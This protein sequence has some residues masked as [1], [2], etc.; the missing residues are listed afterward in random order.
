MKYSW[1]P[2][3]SSVITTKKLLFL[4][5]GLLL[6]QIAFGQSEKWSLGPCLT[7]DHFNEKD[8]DSNSMLAFPEKRHW[9]AS[10]GIIVQRT[11]VVNGLTVRGGLLY[12]LRRWSDETFFLF[13]TSAFGGGELTRVD[14]ESSLTI[15]F[16]R[17]PLLASY[18]F[19]RFTFAVGPSLDIELHQGG[20]SS[21]TYDPPL[22]P[23]P[24]SVELEA[25]QKNVLQ[26]GVRG[27]IAYAWSLS[28]S[29][30]LL[31]GINYHRTLTPR[32]DNNDFFNTNVKIISYGLSFTLLKT[33]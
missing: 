15:G 8:Y 26:L 9:G 32:F 22:P 3:M 20:S 23:D 5:S 10:L 19:R 18:Q 25:N 11:T 2:A 1:F 28:P 12:G 31:T 13:E 4:L 24:E 27:E 29:F 6:A 14:I 17:I 30:Q 7:V 33:L 21:V 16:L